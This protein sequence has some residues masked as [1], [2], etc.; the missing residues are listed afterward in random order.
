MST[1]CVVQPTVITDWTDA[2]ANAPYIAGSAD[3]PRKWSAAA[4]K[5]RIEHERVS[6]SRLD[7]SYGAH[8]RETLD[9]FLPT[10]RPK[11]LA[12]FVHGG[13]WIKLSGKDWSHLAEGPL[14]R[15]FAVAM[16]SYPLCPESSI[17]RITEHIASAI[18]NVAELVSGPIHLAGHSAGGHLVC[19][20]ICQDTNLAPDVLTRIA[21]VLSISGIHDLVPLLKTG[22]NSSLQ[23]NLADAL[24]NS[25]AR[26]MP[27]ENTHVCAWVG[28]N[29]RPE[30][31]RQAALLGSMWNGL[32]AGVSSCVAP[33]NHHFD[34]IDSLQH[35]DSDM[36]KW[37]LSEK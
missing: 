20:Q 25:P 11:G 33:G 6:Q 2:Y 31:L 4:E 27:I 18:N 29:E 1:N 24:K 12:I 5:F 21:R 30:F 13:Y 26:C 28:A 14:A 16:I 10:A 9:L 23:L 35:A 19:R 17:S 22:L 37:W 32:S 34:V 7:I 15:H 3:Y 8:P 36:L